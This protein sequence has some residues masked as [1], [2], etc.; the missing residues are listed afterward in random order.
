VAIE[1]K[2]LVF[3]W[4]KIQCRMKNNID[5][6]EEWGTSSLQARLCTGTL[7]LA[8]Q[9]KSDLNN[10]VKK[11][12]TVYSN[13]KHLGHLAEPS[14]IANLP[15][16]L[17]ENLL[18]CG[19]DPSVGFDLWA[20]TIGRSKLG[21]NIG[22]LPTPKTMHENW[23]DWIHDWL[24]EGYSAKYQI[25]Q[26]NG[27]SMQKTPDDFA[28]NQ[29]LV[30]TAIN[31]FTAEEQ[32]DTDYYG[33]AKGVLSNWKIKFPDLDTEKADSRY[34]EHRS[35]SYLSVKCLCLL[36][37]IYELNKLGQ[38]SDAE[39][40]NYLSWMQERVTELERTEFT[41]ADCWIELLAS[42]IIF[43]QLLKRKF[44]PENYASGSVYDLVKEI[45][46]N[47]NYGNGLALLFIAY[48]A[49]NQESSHSIPQK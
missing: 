15:S 37:L 11:V 45:N 13:S 25:I 12:Q 10:V 31:L 28:Q 14:W 29:L 8:Y 40:S 36:M 18:F 21:M 38:L 20:L 27:E 24:A 34:Y 9:R 48:D 2:D 16:S 32:N 7:Q 30:F 5:T 41:N 19:G 44:I 26:L 39:M 47:S 33:I 6:N 46:E 49:W 43:A 4:E 23:P 42:E 22:N 35:V 17:P 3:N 1:K